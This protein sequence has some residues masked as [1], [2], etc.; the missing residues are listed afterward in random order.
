LVTVFSAPNYSGEFD[1][2]GAIMAVDEN[3][4]CS[5]QQLKPLMKL[6]KGKDKNKMKSFT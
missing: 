6:Q 1:N 5:F 4:M 3:L 2:S